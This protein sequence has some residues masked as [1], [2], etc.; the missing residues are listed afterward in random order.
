ML[1]TKNLKEIKLMKGFF[2]PCKHDLQHAEQWKQLQFQWEW[3][4]LNGRQSE[5]TSIHLTS[6]LNPPPA[7]FP[8]EQLNH[9]DVSELRDNS[10]LQYSRLTAQVDFNLT[11]H[12][13]WRPDPERLSAVSGET[14]EWLPRLR[15]GISESTSRSFVPFFWTNASPDMNKSLDLKLPVQNNVLMSLNPSVIKPRLW[16]E[17][18]FE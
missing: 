8:R 7:L 18:I 16:R 9:V 14:T 2:F 4:S 1:T 6:E 15:H 12:Q 11:L 17:K 5:V 13:S 10:L 3:H